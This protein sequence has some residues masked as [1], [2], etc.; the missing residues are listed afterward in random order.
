MFGRES[1]AYKCCSASP[2]L[3][4]TCTLY[5]ILTSY[6]ANP[7][8][9]RAHGSGKGRR[10]TQRRQGRRTPPNGMFPQSCAA[11]AR[12]A[13]RGPREPSWVAS[14]ALGPGFA[15]GTKHSALLF[16]LKQGNRQSH[17]FLNSTVDRLESK[18]QAYG[19]HFSGDCSRTRDLQKPAPDRAQT[20]HLL[21]QAT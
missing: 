17:L 7:S 19:G 13:R 10:R 15:I 4:L 21:Y 12:E 2:K 20:F 11:G 5:S 16:F 8:C 3:K 1:D 14:R 18:L 6:L 9:N